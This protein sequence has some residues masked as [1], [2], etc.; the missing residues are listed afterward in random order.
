MAIA[1]LKEN[2]RELEKRYRQKVLLRILRF[3][4]IGLL[5]RRDFDERISE[6]IA[7][8]DLLMKSI[9]RHFEDYEALRRHKREAGDRIEYSELADE[10]Q[11][12]A[13]LAT[14]KEVVSSLIVSKAIES[15]ALLGTAV[16]R[17]YEQ[18]VLNLAT[19]FV[20]QRKEDI[21][22]QIREIEDGGTYLVHDDRER[23]IGR[24]KAFEE[25][26]SILETK[27]VLDKEFVSSIKSEVEEYLQF[28][29]DYNRKFIER[30]KKEYNFL[31]RIG[32]LWMRSR[33]KP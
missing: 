19:D 24:L 9:L 21:R 4:L 6:L 5:I 16:L 13:D 10:R 1:E 23:V 18:A 7:R 25:E 15:S 30:R 12:V 26:L 22:K 29:L 3:L 8:N 11:H 27:K 33:R 31:L 28:I 2:T 32:F 20:N 17:D 14:F